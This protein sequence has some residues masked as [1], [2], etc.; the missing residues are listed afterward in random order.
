MHGIPTHSHRRWTNRD[1][2]REFDHRGRRWLWGIVLGVVVAS[3]PFAVWQ[4]QQ[5]ECLRLS[6]GNAELRAQRERLIEE[7][8]RL[9]MQ[10]E[11]LMSLDSIEQW[12]DRNGLVHPSPEQVVIVRDVTAERDEWLA[13]NDDRRGD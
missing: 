10:R 2:T 4:Y 3:S 9:R 1:V 11:S 13:S 5:N 6:Y 7:E 8:R 12:A